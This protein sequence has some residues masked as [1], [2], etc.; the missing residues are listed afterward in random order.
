MSDNRTVASTLMAK[1]NHT[2]TKSRPGLHGSAEMS[3]QMIADMWTV[4]V[5]H[6]TIARN[7]DS[8]ITAVDVSQMMS[9]LKKA[10]AMYGD[11][12]NDDNFVD[13]LGYTALAGMIQLPDPAK[14]PKDDGDVTT[15]G[16]DH[17]YSLGSEPDADG[18]VPCMV[19]GCTSKKQVRKGKNGNKTD[20]VV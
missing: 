4:Y 5:R 8:K 3:F 15:N 16:H 2:I 20:A 19:E 9:L 1:A 11:V 13:D 17:L 6:A 12:M 10:R 7:G 18:F 14:A